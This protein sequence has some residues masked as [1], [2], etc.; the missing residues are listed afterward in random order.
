[1]WHGFESLI[2]DPMLLRR[3]SCVFEQFEVWRHVSP[4]LLERVCTYLT[5]ASLFILCQRCQNYHLIMP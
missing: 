1:M 4:R 2:M 5:G 3:H